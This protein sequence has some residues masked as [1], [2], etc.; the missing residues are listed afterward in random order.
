[1]AGVAPLIRANAAEI[2]AI[3]CQDVKSVEHVMFPRVQSIER[4]RIAPNDID[5]IQVGHKAVLRLLAFNQR[6]TPELNGQVSR[7]SADVT[8]DQKSG[9]N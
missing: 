6:T 5:Q 1:M 3:E 7:V 4:C 2:L 9:T 8:Q